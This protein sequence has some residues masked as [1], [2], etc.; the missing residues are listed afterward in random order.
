MFSR[1]IA[2]MMVAPSSSPVFN[3]PSDHDL[4]Y[5]DVSFSTQDG[6]ELSGWLI[7]G[8]KEKVIIQTHFGVQC[9][10]SGYTPKDK[11]MIRPWK[12]DINFLRQA[13]TFV[14]Q[15]Y[16]VL[17]YDMR[18]HGNS[19]SGKNPWIT[20]GEEEGRDVVAAVDFISNHPDYKQAKIGLMSIC[21]GASASI[22]GFARKK[23]LA[24]Y[25][26]IKAMILVQ[27]LRYAVFAKKLGIPKFLAK[28]A[29]KYNM[30]RGGADLFQS[31]FKY[32]SRVS[33]PTM[34][35]QNT[36]DPW[37]NLEA[38]ESFYN[39]LP[40]EKEMM[41]IELEKNRFAAYDWIGVNADKYLPFFAKHMK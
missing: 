3:N 37:T 13:K 14:D 15:G 29:N 39:Q 41:L 30:K 1:M 36:N 38:L 27:P 35:I 11:G 17:M 34:V 26:N 4:S 6:V 9:S 31:F 16:T 25:P 10:R 33:V 40:V 7:K 32:V 24:N 19:G 20:W 28:S 12:Q 18:H 8:S 23:G 22:W 5:S 21:M 2:D